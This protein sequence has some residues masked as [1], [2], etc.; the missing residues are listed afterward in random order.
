MEACGNACRRQHPA[1]FEEAI[2][3][4]RPYFGAPSFEHFKRHLPGLIVSENM[5]VEGINRIYVESKHPLSLNRFL[6]AGIWK[7]DEVN[8][9]GIAALKAEGALD[10]KGW[11]VIDDT[12]AH[13]TGEM[14]DL[15]FRFFKLN[16]GEPREKDLKR[17][18]VP[19]TSVLGKGTSGKEERRLEDKVYQSRSRLKTFV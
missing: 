7:Q 19:R 8:E 5:T 1:G 3:P 14:I 12:F 15:Q 6:A 9:A 11:I 18:G 16:A 17:E 13:K 10:G 2:E 4:F